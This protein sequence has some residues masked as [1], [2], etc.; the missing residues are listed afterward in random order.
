VQVLIRYRLKPD[1]V[2]RNLALL[3]EVYAELEAVQPEGLREATF[4]LDDE[5]TFLTFVD[6]HPGP[7]VL[8]Q[9]ET[10]QRFRARSTRAAKSR[11]C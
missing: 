9:L 6:L 11:P 8:A 7:E 5:R 1:E 3:R 2:E 4:Q 10:F